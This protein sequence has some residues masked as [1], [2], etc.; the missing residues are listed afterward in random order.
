ME[1][2][3]IVMRE[4]GSF[5]DADVSL[6]LETGPDLLTVGAVAVVPSD[7]EPLPPALVLRESSGSLRFL[8][9]GF[10]ALGIL[11]A[12]CRDARAFSS[13]RPEE[14]DRGRLAD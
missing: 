12:S 1:T 11:L 7:G 2:K 6:F 9:L 4:L 3:A 10:P 13:I 8:L 14:Q 5:S